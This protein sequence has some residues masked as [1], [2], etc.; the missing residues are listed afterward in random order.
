MK[1]EAPECLFFST[2]EGAGWRLNPENYVAAF[3]DRTIC[4]LPSDSY[5]A[6]VAERKV[7]QAERSDGEMRASYRENPQGECRRQASEGRSGG[8]RYVTVISVMAI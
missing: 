5:S 7:E 1:D 2:R 6:L 4:R 8:W 3:S